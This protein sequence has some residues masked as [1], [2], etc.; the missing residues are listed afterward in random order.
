MDAYDYHLI[1][2]L[3]HAFQGA[4]DDERAAERKAQQMSKQG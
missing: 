3:T 1:L 4:L 2:D